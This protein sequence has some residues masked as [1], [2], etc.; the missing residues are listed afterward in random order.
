MNKH[1]IVEFFGREETGHRCGYCKSKESSIADGMWAHYLTCQDYQD[2][3]DRG[4]RRS[5]KYCYKPIMDRTCCP[6]YT[7]RLDVTNAKLRKSQKK[8]IKNFNKYLT[9]G[10]RPKQPSKTD[11]KASGGGE[12]DEDNNCIDEPCGG[13]REVKAP[14]MDISFTGG[15]VNGADPSKPKCRKAKEVRKERKQ[16]KQK[17]NTPHEQITSKQNKNKEKTYE[18]WIDGVPEDAKIKFEVKLVRCC[19]EDEDFKQTFRQELEVY[20]KY[21]IEIH[22]DDPDE[23]DERQF[24][25][26]LCEGPL[27]PVYGDDDEDED[28]DINGIPSCG[29]GAFH[30]QYY[31]DG[32]LV[33]VGVLDILPNIVSSKYL[34]YDPEYQFLSLGTYSALREIYF[35][36]SLYRESLSIKYYYMGFYIHSCLKMKYKGSFFPSYLLCPET[37]MWKSIEDCFEKLDASKYARLEEDKNKVAEQVNASDSLILHK[38]RAMPFQVFI[39]LVSSESEISDH[40]NTV[41]E[42]TTLVGE[43]CKSILLFRS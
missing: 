41:E 33:A 22:K 40:K 28:L 11:Q 23:V 21:Q 19:P 5:G 38:G 20:Q 3:L 35:I 12:V 39:S 1:S 8:V 14:K 32:R 2:L 43:A 42:Y 25:R 24:R 37:Y 16:M 13:A 9:T 6:Q 27:V 18:E 4:W 29:L 7:I 10:I 31:L 30:Q 36:R 26:F 15:I 17:V 34:F